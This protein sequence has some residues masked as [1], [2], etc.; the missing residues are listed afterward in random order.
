MFTKRRS[1]RLRGAKSGSHRSH[2]TAINSRKRLA[3]ANDGHIIGTVGFCGAVSSARTRARAR[4]NLLI[5]PTLD[6]EFLITLII[7][8]P[9]TSDVCAVFAVNLASRDATHVHREFAGTTCGNSSLANR[10]VR[11]ERGL[12]LE[13]S[14]T[15]KQTQ[16]CTESQHGRVA[17]EG[18]REKGKKICFS[19]A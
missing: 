12:Q 18:V 19:V 16:N 10:S 4:R 13:G 3:P 6:V 11:D 1:A 8:H 9:E 15:R 7:R 5:R 2:A 17:S 14:Y